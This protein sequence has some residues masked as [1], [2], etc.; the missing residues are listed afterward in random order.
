MPIPTFTKLGPD[1]QFNDIV[2]KVNTLVAELQNLMLGVDSINVFEVGGWRVTLDQLASSDGDVGMSTTD[3]AGDD[4]RFWAGDA[5]TGSPK[6]TVTK[7]GILTAVDGNF[8]GTITADSGT[9]GGWVISVDSLKD[10]A[11]TVGMS[12]AVTGGDDIRFFAGNATPSSAPFRVTEAGSLTSTSALIQSATG[13]PRVTFDSTNN[14]FRIDQSSTTS[15]IFNPDYLGTTPVINFHDGS[16]DG[17]IGYFNALGKLAFTTSDSGVEMEVSNSGVSGDVSLRPVDFL[18]VPAWSKIF[19]EA[20]SQTLQAALDAKADTGITTSVSV[21]TS[22]DFGAMS[23]TS[24]TLNFTDGVLT[25]V[26]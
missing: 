9:I 15:V 11:G 26:T 17:Y 18:N 19:N 5:K 8:D 22:V 20:A 13:Y 16:I 4:I 24:S 14:N 6:F 12:S 10:A 7:S 3:T 1:P 21:I 25:S 23:T 2:N